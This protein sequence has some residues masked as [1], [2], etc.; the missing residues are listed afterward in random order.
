[1]IEEGERETR[2]PRIS[3]AAFRRV[4]P[5]HPAS[6]AIVPVLKMAVGVVWQCARVE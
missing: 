3:G 6:L 1:M 5:S 2:R 4:H